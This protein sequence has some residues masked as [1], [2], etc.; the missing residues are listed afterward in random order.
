M[1]LLFPTSLCGVLVFRLDPAGAPPPLRLRLLLRR[2]LLL[3]H[4]SLTHSLIHPSHSHSLTTPPPPHSLITHS[5]SHSHSLTLTHFSPPLPHHSP[6][7]FVTHSLTHSLTHPVTLTHSL[8]LT[9]PSSFTTLHYTTHHISLIIH[10]F[11]LH[12]LSHLTAHSPPFTLHMLPFVWQAQCRD[13]PGCLSRGRRSTQS[14]LRSCGARGRRWPAA[15]WL[16]FAWQAQYTEPP[17]WAP[18]AR[19]WL[20]RGRRSTESFLA[21]FRLAGAVHRA[22]WKSCGARG[23]R[24]PA[25][26]F[27][28][29]VAWQAQYTEPPSPLSVSVLHGTSLVLQLFRVSV[30][31][32]MTLFARFGAQ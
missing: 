24:W 15:S 8:L 13:L 21:A 25:A 1:F 4:S 20:S 17:A 2:R 16:P 18:L 7:G 12:H 3:T 11:S 23:R 9:S 26:G 22:S 5:L 6:A 32:I 28:V 27:R 14:L 19:G 29:A 30:C 10:H 31:A